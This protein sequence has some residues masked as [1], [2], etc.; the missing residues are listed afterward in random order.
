[1]SEGRTRIEG[2][3]EDT[4]VSAAVRYYIKDELG[5]PI[6]LAASDGGLTES[7]GYDEFGQDL[8]GNQG[9][10][11]SFGYTGY[12]RDRIAG[13]YYANARE[14]RTE[15][16]RFAAV[17][18]MKGF[19][20]APMTLNEYGYCWNQPLNLVDINGREPSVSVPDTETDYVGVYY[21][22]SEEGAYTFGHA[23]L[24]LVREDGSGTFYSFAAS[25]R[26][27]VGIVL[28]K[29]VDGYLSKAEIGAKDVDIFL[30][31]AP[32]PK[33]KELPPPVP[34][35]GQ[36]YTDSITGKEFVDSAETP[37]SHYIYIPVTAQEGMAMYDYAEQ[38]RAENETAK[39]NLYTRNCSMIAQDILGAGGKKFAVGPREGSAEDEQRALRMLFIAALTT[40]AA[41]PNPG[42]PVQI[43]EAT[44]C[45]DYLDQT[46]PK[47]AYEAG[48][49]MVKPDGTHPDWEV[50]IIEG[51]CSK[52]LQL[53]NEGAFNFRDTIS[54]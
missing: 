44:I 13:T 49:S 43:I 35:A 38:L 33:N 26:D 36:I 20:S 27:A 54:F 7:Y 32:A 46:I 14:Y 34:N 2:G 5:S 39:Y 31:M 41:S 16:G 3:Q 10:V 11:Q 24:L 1:M 18:V 6:R 28:G 47:G 52:K 15:Q 29:D 4:S 48:C 40:G 53:L 37:Y 8:Y 21:L 12:Q 22:L 19:M 42:L 25:P 51:N 23:A 9:K 17:D 50:G 30:G 45:Q